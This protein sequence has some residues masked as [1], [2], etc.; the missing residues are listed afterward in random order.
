[1][2]G[3]IVLDIPKNC[4]ECE[5]RSESGYCIPT[6][7]DVF[8]YALREEKA[9]WCPIKQMPY[10]KTLFDSSG[11]QKVKVDYCQGWNDCIKNIL[12]EQS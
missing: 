9:E 11:N 2:K 6:H 8:R 12:D 4:R 1:M 7:K 10:K 5:M 3:I